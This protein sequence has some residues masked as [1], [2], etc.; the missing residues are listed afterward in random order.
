MSVTDEIR[1]ATRRLHSATRADDDDEAQHDTHEC[2]S[3]SP[4][5]GRGRAKELDKFTKSL[6]TKSDRRASRRRHTGAIPRG[7]YEGHRE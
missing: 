5:P 3:R 7:R 2:V 4:E 6:L 1:A